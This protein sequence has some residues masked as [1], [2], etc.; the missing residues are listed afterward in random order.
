MSEASDLAMQE[1]LRSM[2]NS[3]ASLNQISSE[4]LTSNKDQAKGIAEIDNLS[5]KTS[6]G[7]WSAAN[8]I[9]VVGKV[10]RMVGSE[11]TTALKGGFDLQKRALSR[12][13]NLDKVM[14]Q[15]S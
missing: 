12:G 4:I 6:K 7:V 5:G 13:Q 3:L 1:S 15:N 2:A 11:I 14:K 10:M 8:N 9:P